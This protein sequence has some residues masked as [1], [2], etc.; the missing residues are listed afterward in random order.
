VAEN[1]E[2]RL[3]LQGD[4]SFDPG[5]DVT[6]IDNAKGLEFDYV[7]VPDA[8]AGAYPATDEAR[9]RLHVAITRAAHQLWI[10][11]GGLASPL[12]PKD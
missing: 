5:I 4:F 1:S 12:L 7:V 9:R 2:A 3:V 10:V 6:D 11:A 8:T